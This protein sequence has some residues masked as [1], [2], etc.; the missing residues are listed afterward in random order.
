VINDCP[1]AAMH[2]N[3]QRGVGLTN[4]SQRLQ[5]LY[6]DSAQTSVV[7]RSDAKFQVDV[8]MPYQA[9]LQVAPTWSNAA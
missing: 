2:A 9:T 3:A 7:A 1:V 5:A 4:I 8:V 6:G